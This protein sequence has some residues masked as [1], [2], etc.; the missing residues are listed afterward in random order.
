MV[1]I[2]MPIRIYLYKLLWT[3]SPFL[4]GLDSA[5]VYASMFILNSPSRLTEVMG[6]SKT[7]RSRTSL[8]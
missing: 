8:L 2:L 4:A 5:L 7:H 1:D 6:W 3:G